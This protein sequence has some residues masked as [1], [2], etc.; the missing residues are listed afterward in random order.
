MWGAGLASR[1]NA[2][3][4]ATDADY[5]FQIADCAVPMVSHEIGQWCVYPNLEEIEKYTG[6]LRAVNY[7]LVQDSLAEHDMLDQAKEF[8][9]A[10]GAL[11]VREYK[12]EIESALRTP[13]FGGFEL[14]GASDYPGEGTALVGVLDAFWDAKPISI[15]RPSP[16]SVRVR[17]RWRG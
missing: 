3:P 12:E 9:M 11:Q 1:M 10:S 4:P 13:G 8:T 7:E 6:L 5:R 15:E 17:C 2:R 16:S 14:L